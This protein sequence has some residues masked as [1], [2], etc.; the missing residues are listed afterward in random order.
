M[1]LV[2]DNGNTRAKVAVFSD[3]GEE[4]LLYNWQQPTLHDYQ[5]LLSQYEIDAALICSVGAFSDEIF[6]FLKK[7]IPLVIQLDENT[8]LPLK[9]GYATP[10]TLGYDRLAVAVGANYLHPDKPLLIIDAGTAITYEFVSEDNTYCGGNIAPGVSMRMRSMHDYTQK[11]PLLEPCQ[12]DVP[13]GAMGDNTHDAMCWGVIVGMT[14]EIEGYIDAMK[15]KY[16]SILIFLTGGDA[17]FFE[18]RLKSSIFVSQNLLLLGLYC[19]LRYNQC[20]QIDQQ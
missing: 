12:T 8:P 16:P 9:N 11:L 17:F 1:K 19:I 15:A 20:L 2:V 3:D 14:Y 4:V 5:K 10:N 18:R 13:A 6:V 7:S